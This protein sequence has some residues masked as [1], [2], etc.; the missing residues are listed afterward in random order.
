L[1]AHD[2]NLLS[3]TTQDDCTRLGLRA[4]LKKVVAFTAHLAL[5]KQVTAAKAV[6]SEL[7]NRRLHRTTARRHR[8]LE[9]V[10]RNPPGAENVA[11]GEP[12]SSDVANRQL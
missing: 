10:V 4:T 3:A 11:V 8:S 5:L 7:G 12:L 2:T 1:S 9:V 6:K